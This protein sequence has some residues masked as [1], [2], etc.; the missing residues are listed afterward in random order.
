MAGRFNIIAQGGNRHHCVQVEFLHHRNLVDFNNNTKEIFNIM[1]VAGKY[2]IIGS[3]NISN[4][5][6]NSDYDLQE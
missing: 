3:S 4:L 1:S 5:I 2:Q 6:Y